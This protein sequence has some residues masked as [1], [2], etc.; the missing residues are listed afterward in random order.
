M[1]FAQ[2]CGRPRKN[3][4]FIALSE[5]LKATFIALN[6][7]NKLE[8]SSAPLRP[9]FSLDSSPGFVQAASVKGLPPLLF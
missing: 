7:N 3:L 6:K 4:A 8:R 2:S 5:P 1:F 9:F